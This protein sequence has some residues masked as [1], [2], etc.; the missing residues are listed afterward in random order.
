MLMNIFTTTK[1]CFNTMNP[2]FKL[3]T[4]TE[5]AVC[6]LREEL[7]MSRFFTDLYNLGLENHSPHQLD[8]A[9]IIFA[10]LGLQGSDAMFERYV[11]LLA[12]HTE[13]VHLTNESLAKEALAFCTALV[14]FKNSG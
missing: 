12:H 7:K 1:T 3:P 13:V 14:V 4:H 11:E 10:C 9:P 5:L 6:L 2:L 8:L